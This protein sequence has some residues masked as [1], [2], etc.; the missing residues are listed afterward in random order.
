M[1]PDHSIFTEEFIND[2][3]QDFEMGLNVFVHCKTFEK[4]Y[5][6][7]PD[8]HFGDELEVWQEDIDKVQDD[9]KNY[10]QIEKWPSYQTHDIMGRFA[11]E[12]VHQ[13][14]LKARIIA[15]L[16]GRK[17][18]QNFNLIV[19]Q[20]LETRK[21]WFDYKLKHEMEWVRSKLHQAFDI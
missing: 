10:I 16:E 14:M 3:A 8:T 20:S 13:P 7:D 18:F 21:I 1:A 2:I 9:P 11:E 4:I 15:A 5:F 6:P 17:P 19:E 12:M